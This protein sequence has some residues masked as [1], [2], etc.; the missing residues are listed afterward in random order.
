MP[1]VG[2]NRRSTAPGRAS[3]RAALERLNARHPWSHNDHFHAWILANLPEQRR[4]ALDVGCGE[5]ELLAA[6]AP[7]FAQVHGNDVDP[8]MRQQAEQRCAG[9]SHVRIDGGPWTD[10]PQGFDLV[11]MVAV[12]HHLDLPDALQ[13]ARRLLEPRGRFLAVGL[14][15]AA[16]LVDHAWDVASALTN[17]LIGYVKHPW[18]NRNGVP[19][20]AFPV[21]EPTRTFRDVRECVTRVMPGAAMRHHLGFRHTI[22][23][24]KPV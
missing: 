24:T 9:L 14:A 4:A 7:Y 6:L 3:L 13:E 18:P 19:P 21:R 20:P 5:G 10:L 17:P 15:P 12:M 8:T 23:W 22:A 16:T 11:T 2:V 1:V